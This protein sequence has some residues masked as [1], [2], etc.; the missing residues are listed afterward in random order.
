MIV[1]DRKVREITKD[2]DT[3]YEKRAEMLVE[4]DMG[5]SY[6]VDSDESSNSMESIA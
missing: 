5:K 2:L 4:R 3:M 6:P 1:E